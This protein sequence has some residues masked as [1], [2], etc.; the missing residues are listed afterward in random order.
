MVLGWREIA[1]GCQRAPKEIDPRGREKTLLPC[2]TRLYE[3]WHKAAKPA[4]LHI[5]TGGGFGMRV[6]VNAELEVEAGTY[7]REQRQNQINATA[8]APESLPRARASSPPWYGGSPWSRR[9]A[10]LLGFPRRPTG[11]RVARRASSG[12]S[13]SRLGAADRC[14]T[15]AMLWLNDE[16]VQDARRSAERH[17]VVPLDS[18]LGVADHVPMGLG[19]EDGRVRVF[20]FCP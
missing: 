12:T 11:R 17:V 9:A 20:E 6:P 14:P 15:A 10:A 18:G 13:G 5:F 2:A 19:D 16:V 1:L 3:A 4:E 8:S 7:V